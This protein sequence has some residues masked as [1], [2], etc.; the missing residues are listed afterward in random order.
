MDLPLSAAEFYTGNFNLKP[1]DIL[2]EGPGGPIVGAFLRL[3][4]GKE[5]VDH[6]EWNYIVERRNIL[7]LD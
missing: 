3:D 5:R 4:R 1:I 7:T 2:T 6:R